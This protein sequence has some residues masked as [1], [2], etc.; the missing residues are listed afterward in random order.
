MSW[1]VQPIDIRGP[2]LKIRS[3]KPADFETI[4][5]A[6][7]EPGGFY[8]QFFGTDS[9]EKIIEMLAANHQAHLARLCNPIVFELEGEVVGI[10]RFFRFDELRKSLEIGGTWI[11]AKWRR[12]H[13][14]TEA[15]L[16]L[17]TYAFDVLRMERVEYS[18]NS[19]NLRSQMAVLRLGAK[20]EGLMR[21]ARVTANGDAYDGVLYSVVKPEWEAVATRLRLLLQR[22]PC[23]HDLLPHRLS[24]NRTDLKRYELSD[25]QSLLDCIDRNRSSIAVSFPVSAKAKSV[26]EVEAFIVDKAH[27]F[28]EGS[29]FFWGIWTKGKSSSL[30]GQVHL[31]NVDWSLKSAELGY[32]IDESMRRQGYAKEVLSTLLQLLRERLGFTRLVVRIIPDNHPSLKLA[33]KLGFREEGV[34]RSAFLTGRGEVAD[35]V[36]MS[37]IPSIGIEK[38]TA[39]GHCPHHRLDTRPAH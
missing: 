39:D 23:E 20:R 4:A 31:I 29:R 37:L 24:T 28:A 15:K 34:M 2:S 10:T 38:K 6:L 33:R 13:V 3:I 35:I 30:I 9:S 22:Q 5:E 25:A 16:L 21:R 26:S 8:A 11:A 36:L 12:T 7:H 19:A 14:N 27:A 1:S 18:V 17:M 32:Y